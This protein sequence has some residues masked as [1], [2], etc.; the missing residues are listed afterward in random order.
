MCM[1]YLLF[2]LVNNSKDSLTLPLL[3]WGKMRV[4]FL[5]DLCLFCYHS[6][7]VNGRQPNRI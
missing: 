1:F 7:S 3:V 5:L 4:V 2:L 6:N